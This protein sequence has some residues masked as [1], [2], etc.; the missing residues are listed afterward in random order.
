MVVAIVML[1]QASALAAAYGPYYLMDP[2]SGKCI[3]DPKSNMN[4]NIRMDIYTCLDAANEL[5]WNDDMPGPGEYWIKDQVS[6]KCLTVLNAETTRNAPVIQYTCTYGA[7]EVWKYIPYGD[8]TGIISMPTGLK[9]Y[10]T[11]KIMN[12]NSRMCLTVRD[13]GIDNGSLLLQ[14]DCDTDGSN[15]WYQIES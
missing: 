3:D 15:V 10:R 4:N 5:W 9:V 13:T 14:Y 11:Y 1:P 12:E 2:Y 7:N 8:G 6:G